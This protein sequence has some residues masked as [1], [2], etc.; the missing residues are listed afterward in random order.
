MSAIRFVLGAALLS[1]FSTSAFAKGK[2]VPGEG[3]CSEIDA[4]VYFYEID[5][6][7]IPSDLKE[8]MA[9]CNEWAKDPK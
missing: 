5:G 7:K 2:F 3:V 1:A 9:M 6:R 4:K 8:M